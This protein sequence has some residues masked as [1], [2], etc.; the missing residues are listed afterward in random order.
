MVSRFCAANQRSNL[1]RGSRPRVSR[2][3][4]KEAP[5]DLTCLNA[6][7]CH[8]DRGKLRRNEGGLFADRVDRD[9]FT[10]AILAFV[11]DDPVNFGEQSVISS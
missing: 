6:Y 5:S 2:D 8:R 3:L 10:V 1:E 9:L 7:R 11:F 4:C